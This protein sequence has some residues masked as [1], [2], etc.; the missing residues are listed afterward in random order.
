M[1]SCLF[2]TKKGTPQCGMPLMIVQRCY[3]LD[4]NRIDGLDNTASDLVGVTL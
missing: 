3:N 1:M 4:L 2:E